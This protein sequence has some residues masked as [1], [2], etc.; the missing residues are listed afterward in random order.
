MEKP[1]LR[2]RASRGRLFAWAGE[3]SATAIKIWRHPRSGSREDAAGTSNGIPSVLLLYGEREEAEEESGSFGGSEDVE[4]DEETKQMRGTNVGN[5][6]SQCGEGRKRER[7]K[8]KMLTTLAMLD[9]KAML[10]VSAE[11]REAKS[12]HGSRTAAI[13][14][15]K[16][17][18]SSLSF[19]TTL[20]LYRFPFFFYVTPFF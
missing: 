13:G 2:S 12:S 6:G 10:Y 14:I 11:G 20:S 19:P 1:A 3:G 9:T 16:R 15:N 5:G 18:L 4:K 8:A 17:L 7:P